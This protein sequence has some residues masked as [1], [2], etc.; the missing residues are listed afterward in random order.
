M[1]PKGEG[2]CAANP[3]N[4]LASQERISYLFR[5]YDL[6]GFAYDFSVE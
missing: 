3:R 6:S 5:G 2:P 4:S 1:R